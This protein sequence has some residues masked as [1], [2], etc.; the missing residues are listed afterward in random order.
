[1]SEGERV[2]VVIVG[3]GPVGLALAGE[4]AWRGQRVIVLERSD[5][6]IVQPRM[7]LVGVRTMEFCR[8]WGLVEAVEASR[9]NRA[10]A[11][12]NVYV[13]S[14]TGF[15][16]GRERVSSM[17]DAKPPPQSPQK[18]ERCPQD[19]FDPILADWVRS[20]P[21]V[22]VRY[23]NEFE[24]FEERPDSVAVDVRDTDGGRT[25]R[26]EAAYLIGCDGASTR[27]GAQLGIEKIGTPVLT[28]TT[29]VIFR[30]RELASL[31]DKGEAYRF[32][33][34][35]NEGTWATIVAI[36]GFERYR[37]S[38]VRSPQGGHSR[39][40]IEAAIRRAVGCDFAFDVQSITNWT[41]AE[42]VAAE[43]GHGRAFVAGDAAHVMSPTGGFGMNTGIGDAVDLAWK[44]DALLTGWGGPRLLE[45]YAAERRPVAERNGRESSMN[46]ARMTPLGTLPLMLEPT[47]AGQRFRAEYGA[48]F[49]ETMRHEWF[50][51]GIHLGY[52]Y[53]ASPIC[54]PDG[55]EAPP[56]EVATYQQIAR[57]GARAP[58]V[59]LG[60]GRS[61]LD[62]FGR[63]FVLLRF[64]EG[65]EVAALLEAA[66]SRNVPLRVEDIRHEA[67]H[68]AY[69]SNLVLVR[70]DGH[71]AWRGDV[72]PADTEA[73]ID[74][75]RG[76]Q[77]FAWLDAEPTSMTAAR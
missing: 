10:L 70:P 59:W 2:P 19:M 25:Y 53:D 28:N 27:V 7:D 12:D 26:L 76:A 33:I 48:A 6:T 11:Q 52:R 64:R 18:R 43:Y 69:E 38:I 42:L 23:R 21:K 61:T 24:A 46:L 16:L 20:F 9:Y 51:L 13:T 5:G 77:P 54:W 39:D 67:A 62:L 40:A 75:V 41:R 71:V 65:A 8:R 49:S 1:M 32:I 63:G 37:F 68:A 55:S 56:M 34:L 36:D 17:N 29:N 14:L 47:P 44:L 58:H 31:H 50:T 73:L 15:E 72:L 22:D 3:A 35:G 57:P 4:L 74:C 66:R 30:S 60:E 45:T